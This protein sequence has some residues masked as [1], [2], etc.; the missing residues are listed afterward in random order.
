MQRLNPRII[1]VEDGEDS[2]LKGPE[3]IFNKVI[4]EKFSNLKKGMSMNV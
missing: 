1:G 4:E 2:I 3:I